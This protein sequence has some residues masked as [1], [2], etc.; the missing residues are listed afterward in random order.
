MEAL[1]EPLEC[2]RARTRHAPREVQ[3]EELYGHSATLLQGPG[4]RRTVYITGG[5][6]SRLKEM[7][8]Y[9]LD[10]D[11]M[12]WADRTSEAH[13]GEGGVGPCRRWGHSTCLV[14]GLYHPAGTQSA[15]PAMLIYGGFDNQC[16]HHDTWVLQ[17]LHHLGLSGGST[18]A[19]AASEGGFTRGTTATRFGPQTIW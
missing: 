2:K 10:L 19:A 15:P 3:G 5:I 18:T 4:A 12:C 1:V 16:N 13:A 17:G 11:S 7:A 8:V 6:H 9:T 14:P